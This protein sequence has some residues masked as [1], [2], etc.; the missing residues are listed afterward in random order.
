[1]PAR[2]S[3]H[4]R[5]D[6]RRACANQVESTLRSSGL[7]LTMGGE[8]TYIALDPAG[9]E[10]STSA[11]GP[12]KLGYARRFCAAYLRRFHPGAL[13]THAYGKQY[14]NE[15]LPR[16]TVSLTHRPGRPIWPATD[17]LLLDDRAPHESAARLPDLA[18]SI[19][20]TLRLSRFLRP[21]HEEGLAPTAAPKGW[22]LP[23]DHGAGGWVSDRWKM[24]PGASVT[25]I[26]GDSSI[27]LRLPLLS[28]P[29]A[30]LKRAMTVEL[31]DG[32]LEIFIPPL[33]AAA[34]FELLGILHDLAEKGDFSPLVISGYFPPDARGLLRFTFASDPGVI[35]VNLPPASDWSTFQSHLQRLDLAAADAGLRTVKYHFNGF[36][37]GTGGGA[38]LCFGGP[39]ARRSPFL[40]RRN[41]LP[42]VLR[43]FQNHP[44]LAY[45]FSGMFVGPNSQAPRVDETGTG[46]LHEL[47]L[48]LAGSGKV[49]PDPFLFALL[50]RDLLAD[51][52]GNTHR[53]EISIDKLWNPASPTG[54][55]GIVEF[56]AVESTADAAALGTIALLFRAILARIARHPYHASLHPWAETL[57]DRFF[58]PTLLWADLGSVAADLRRHGIAFDPAWL[59]DFWA[60]RFPLLGTLSGPQGKLTV[61][62]ALES[63]PLLGEQPA[64]AT[65]VRAIDSS[66]ERLEFRTT[67]ADASRS[68]LLVQG[69]EVPFRACG[70]W[71][72]A[73]LTFRAHYRVPSL[74]PHIPAQSP[75]ILDWIDRRS[76]RIT[77]S[78][79]WHSWRPNGKQ[80]DSRPQNADEA[81]Q[82]VRERWIPR[83]DR[84]GDKARPRKNLPPSERWTHDLRTAV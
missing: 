34:Y 11:L 71:A 37:Q 58:L 24:P 67:R 39:V 53:A 76:G 18:V 2:L 64:G 5:S 27:G 68:W 32:G 33:P 17:R 50:F 63:W 80:Y 21:A 19:A 75:L 3:V 30:C 12:T 22:V 43:Y 78:V 23:L 65:T 44:S 10:W 16:W 46:V 36:T 74:H 31:K 14:P 38:H 48:A 25:L 28:L 82:R 1:M 66:N 69:V 73:G 62:H 54:T 40:E 41:F 81:S 15:P 84:I 49:E 79:E 61:T 55:M 26:P 45:A 70:R 57:H 35:E 13:V 59:K 29:E 7:R 42:G 8:P 72:L 9:E 56:R 47:E 20:R 77:N 51:R 60:W 83:P 52:S 6:P 4:G